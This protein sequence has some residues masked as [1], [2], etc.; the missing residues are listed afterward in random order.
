MDAAVRRG[1]IRANPLD[2]L[3][4]DDRPATAKAEH[5]ESRPEDLE[6]LFAASTKIARQG[7]SRYDYTPL[8]RL[9]AR[10]GLRIG[11]ALGLQW[12]DFDK[13]AATLTIS[14]QWTRYG[15]YGGPKTQAGRRTV[16]LPADVVEYLDLIRSASRFP[17]ATSPIFA[18]NVGTPLTHR[19]VTKRGWEPARRLAGLEGATLRGLR[20]AAFSRLHADTRIDGA[21]I[22]DQL[23]HANVATLRSTYVHR[24]RP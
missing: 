5:F 23:G 20:H 12:Q 10:L 6:A 8:L 1:K 21:T 2:K 16:Y 18:S 22:A 15:E 4:E 3:T 24:L 13:A 7:T 17:G 14:R 11:E 9:T 19:N